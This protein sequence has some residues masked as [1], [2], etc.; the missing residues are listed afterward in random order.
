[1][2]GLPPESRVDYYWYLDKDENGV[3]YYDGYMNL[4]KIKSL[5]KFHNWNLITN[6]G[7]KMYN[8]EIQN[9]PGTP[10]GSTL[11]NTSD[12][13]RNVILSICSLGDHFV[14]GNGECISKY[15]RCDNVWDCGDHSDERNCKSILVPTY[16]DKSKK[17]I[18]KISA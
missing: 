12:S 9:V 15:K 2:L 11:W 4:G 6:D 7:L 16:Y 18:F 13:K 8:I 14:C 17:R 3:F 1:M 10:V 5:N